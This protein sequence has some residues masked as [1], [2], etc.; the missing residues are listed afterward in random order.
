MSRDIRALGRWTLIA[1]A[2]GLPVFPWQRQS[3]R[4]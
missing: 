4:V 2:L 1:L 3:R